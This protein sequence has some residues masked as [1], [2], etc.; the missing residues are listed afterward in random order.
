MWNNSRFVNLI[1]NGLTVVALSALAVAAVVWIGQRPVFN[2]ARIEVEAAPGAALERV[3]EPGIRATIA[4]RI[5]GNFF[6]SDLE[7]VR[8]VFETVPWVRQAMVRRVWPDG[9]EVTLR[10]Y[11]PLGLWNDNQVLDIEG[12]VFTANQAEAEEVDGR[13]L[14]VL[15]GPEGSGPLVKQRLAEL[16]EWLQ[17]LGR[18][19]TRLMLSDR[20]AWRAQLDNGMVL[21]LGRDPSTAW[22]QEEPES[23]GDYDVPIKVRVQRFVQGLQAVEER[24]GQPVIYADLRYPNGFAVRLGEKPKADKKSKSVNKP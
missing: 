3:S 17:P 2:L 14:P 13:R 15:G 16:T 8:Q 24:V 4:G 12:R 20:Y 22:S 21:D 23:T 9:L 18:V 10:E 1:A 5:E 19:P 11:Q 7:S 6:T